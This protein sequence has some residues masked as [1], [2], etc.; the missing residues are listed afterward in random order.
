L[1]V[2]PYNDE[3]ALIRKMVEKTAMLLK[4]QTLYDRIRDE[5]IAFTR[6]FQPF[7]IFSQIEKTLAGE[8]LK[9]ELWNLNRLKNENPPEY[10]NN[11][12][13]S[14]RSLHPQIPLEG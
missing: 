9:T 14:P 2:N 13:L 8:C 10:S 4:D 7:R 6:R 1:T 5:N 12:L 3:A 11:Q